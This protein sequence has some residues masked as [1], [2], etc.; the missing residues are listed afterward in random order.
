MSSV[1]D[2]GKS[3]ACHLCLELPP[4][5]SSSKKLTIKTIVSTKKK[6]RKQ[7]VVDSDLFWA[8]ANEAARLNQLIDVG[9]NGR[10]VAAGLDA[11]YKVILLTFLLHGGPG[12]LRQHSDLLVALLTEK[13]DK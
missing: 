2:A 9:V 4:L 11:L 1:V 5:T 6:E 3:S 7:R 10:E 13:V 12:L 8:A